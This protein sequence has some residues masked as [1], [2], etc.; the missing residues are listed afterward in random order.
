[1]KEITFRLARPF[2][3]PEFIIRTDCPVLTDWLSG[4]YG[5]YLHTACGPAQ[6]ELAAYRNPVGG[7]TVSYGDYRID[8][9]S[10]LFDI[11]RLA[12][13]YT[14]YDP[15]VLALHG[16]SVAAQGKAQV[17]LAATTS[18]KTTLT[19]YLTARGAPYLTDDCVLLGRAD[20]LIHPCATPLHL[21]EGA[22][23]VLDSC[24][25]SPPYRYVDDGELQR[26]A[27]VPEIVQEDPIPL[28]NLYFLSRSEAPENRLEPIPQT[29]AVQLLM[30]SVMPGYRITGAYL[31]LLAG[32]AEARCFRLIYN[33]MAF[34]EACIYGK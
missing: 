34:V 9:C 2:H 22:L 7:Y 18:G 20:R 28:G 27:F 33:D 6:P 30:Q 8:T 19:A 24:G 10:P 26:Y 16:A 5:K 25:I 23:S 14:T 4:Y 3:C 11:N 15:T 12:A 29:Q 17:F 1:M 32:L 21:R 13:E 31:R